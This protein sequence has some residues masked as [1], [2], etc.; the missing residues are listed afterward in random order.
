[1][2]ILRLKVD[3][4]TQIALFVEMPFLGRRKS[5]DAGRRCPSWGR[6]KSEDAGHLGTHMGPYVLDESAPRAA[7]EAS[8]E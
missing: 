4:R 7:D 1:M 3:H 6:R 5:E 2:L 8:N